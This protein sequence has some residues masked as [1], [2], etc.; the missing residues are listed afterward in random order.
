MMQRKVFANFMKL[1][2]NA[3]IYL[4]CVF[5]QLVL[6]ADEP[7]ESSTVKII[8]GVKDGILTISGVAEIDSHDK[9]HSKPVTPEAASKESSKIAS[10]EP[11]EKIKDLKYPAQASS[12]EEKLKIEKLETP[13]AG[14]AYPEGS[15]EPFGL[16]IDLQLKKADSSKEASKESSKIGTPE[17]EKDLKTPEP[18]EKTPSPVQEK[19]K[20]SSKAIT[21]EPE[22]N[23]T[24]AISEEIQKETKS[25]SPEPKEP[26]VVEKVESSSPDQDTVKSN[27]SSKAVTLTPKEESQNEENLVEETELM[28]MT[29]VKIISEVK[30]G[31]PTVLGLTQVEI[32]S[33]KT[34]PAQH[35]PVKS[36]SK[37]LDTAHESKANGDVVRASEESIFEEST[38]QVEEIIEC[39]KSSALHAIDFT[40]EDMKQI[41]TE[42]KQV[43]EKIIESVKTEVATKIQST[44]QDTQTFKD[45][46]QKVVDDA[47]KAV[48][49]L[50]ESLQ[51]EIIESKKLIAEQTEC[52]ETVAQKNVTEIKSKA[53]TEIEKVRKELNDTKQ[54][55]EDLS[56]QTKAAAEE[57]KHEISKEVKK[58]IDN[59]Q[60]IAKHDIQE[61]QVTAVSGITSFF[62]GLS[63]EIKSG[64]DKVADSV[65]ATLSGAVEKIEEKI[66]EKTEALI[67][68]AEEEPV[69]EEEI[70]AKTIPT[71]MKEV[72]TELRETHITTVDSPVTDAQMLSSLSEDQEM[73]SSSFRIEEIKYDTGLDEIKEVEEEDR[74]SPPS[75]QS[76]SPKLLPSPLPP[77]ARTPEYV[78]KIVAEVAEVL[79][80]DKDIAEIIPDFDETEL[81]RRLSQKSDDT[82]SVHRM[83]VTATSEDGG[84]QTE[85]C[86]EDNSALKH[87]QSPDLSGKS[88]PDIK[89]DSV[90]H[91][92]SQQKHEY[93]IEQGSPD[94]KTSPAS[95]E[96][97]DKHEMSEKAL[98]KQDIQSTAITETHKDSVTSD[99]AETDDIRRESTFSILSEKDFTKD[100]SSVDEHKHQQESRPQSVASHDEVHDIKPDSKPTSETGSIGEKTP[101][102]QQIS[103]IKEEKQESKTPSSSG[104]ISPSA[105]EMDD[106][107]KFPRRALD[108]SNKH[109]ENF[110]P[111][112]GAK[113]TEP[114]TKYVQLSPDKF[115]ITSETFEQ[116]QLEQTNFTSF[117]IGTVDPS[118]DDSPDSSTGS[119]K[120][121]EQVD[122]KPFDAH[123]VHDVVIKGTRSK[124]VST[125]ETNANFKLEKNFIDDTRKLPPLTESLSS[126]RESLARSSISIDQKA[127]ESVDL[128]KFPITEE[129]TLTTITTVTEI[130]STSTPEPETSGVSGKLSPDLPSKSVSESDKKAEFSTDISTDKPK[131][132]SSSEK[133]ST[134]LDKD[135]IDGSQKS[136]NTTIEKDSLS[137]SSKTTGEA[138]E[139]IVSEAKTITTTTSHIMTEEKSIPQISTTITETT[140][141]L[142]S[143]SG[144]KTPPTAPVSPNIKSEAAQK[145]TIEAVL[146][147]SALSSTHGST[148]SV[149]RSIP[150]SV[151]GPESGIETPESSPKPT[152]P[153]PKGLESIKA[154]EIGH[155]SGLS[156]PE[157]A[158]TPTPDE[159]T[160]IETIDG[161]TTVTKTI[162]TTVTTV[163]TKDGDTIV[164]EKTTTETLSGDIDESPIHTIKDPKS[165]SSILPE[166]I[167]S[168]AT[169]EHDSEDEGAC[170]AL[171]TS[172]QLPVSPYVA[173]FE[174]ENE[175]QRSSSAISK[176]SDADDIDESKNEMPPHYDSEEARKAVT[177]S[178]TFKPDPMSTSFYGTLPDVRESKT[179]S[180]SSVTFMTDYC[181]TVSSPID[182]A[183]Y[184]RKPSGKFLDD[185]DLDFDKAMDSHGKDDA[186]TKEQKK[187]DDKEKKADDVLKSWGKPLG[188]PSPA[189]T[190]AEPESRTTPKKERRQVVTK[191]KLNNEKNLRKRGE[192]PANRKKISPVYV[193]LAYV[194]HNGNSNYSHIE[195]FRRIRARYY[196]FSGTE[197]SRE[198][199]NALLEAKQTWEDKDLGNLFLIYKNSIKF[200][201]YLI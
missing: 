16:E 75:K 87:E 151:G 56:N 179:E 4:F 195:F 79:K 144:R 152:V 116:E 30:D 38:E 95:I 155:S 178:S 129:S 122:A 93:S 147:Q 31:V 36:P 128:T 98:A 37:S 84:G 26:E 62:G 199:Y 82:T 185:A 161:T 86:E 68:K 63:K 54:E 49:N 172:P 18:H 90:E 193:D 145:E 97:K 170:S 191:T 127:R 149:A 139:T 44:E 34:S 114:D 164:S 120:A 65:G 174:S 165:T 42:M 113:T 92:D 123:E 121:S 43:G 85:I 53:Q 166:L 48:E 159:T 9:H 24:L 118:N 184:P 168:S 197:P 69:I 133:S 190:P 96:E 5:L 181:E 66:E 102:K 67:Q 115:P 20:D 88:S 107:E 137:L 200:S 22:S 41:E 192:S 6:F 80:S 1:S 126:S 158:R 60:S 14:D 29:T 21:P 77:R 58:T 64:I 61:T 150:M 3:L 91:D 99:K 15:N 171:S 33:G 81:E 163:T 119:R 106:D 71:I 188:L 117:P 23:V 148:E 100:E 136:D 7:T 47:D 8:S 12:P 182:V 141:I 76:G 32:P 109:Q 103:E 57:L 72:T 101:E 112:G 160:H 196:V 70:V 111:V 162:I 131:S 175:S 138:V 157:M 110:S 186:Q 130:T 27:E 189:L 134:Q 25:P 40:K 176:K 78:E 143:S 194:P 140:Q 132:V 142:D 2:K 89:I 45:E 94:Q 17:P 104:K 11:E 108:E 59:I 198:A 180:T 167:E 55:I 51:A 135:S 124:S 105:P 153:F 201:L 39:M 73:M 173:K 13:E 177:I 183:D 10:P 74:Y 154:D 169:E 46:M 50:V 156:S 52:L 125:I 19:S 83:L 35:S 28:E 187:E 146:G